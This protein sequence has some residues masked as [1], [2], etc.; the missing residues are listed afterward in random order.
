MSQD[1]ETL[2][3]FN[4]LENETQFGTP[5]T[6]FQIPSYRRTKDRPPI[7][8]YRYCFIFWI[9]LGAMASSSLMNVQFQASSS[10]S[11]VKDVAQLERIGAHSHITGLGLNELLEVVES[12]SHKDVAAAAADSAA[13]TAAQ[14][15]SGLVGQVKARRALGIIAKLIQSQQISGRSVLLAGP[16]STGK[17]ALAM[18]LAT[19]LLGCSTTATSG[20]TSRNASGTINDSSNSNNMPFVNLAASSVYSVDLSKTEALTQAVR[21]SIGVQIQEEA[22]LIVGEVVEIQVDTSTTAASATTGGGLKKTGRI[23]L[24]TT[25]METV[26]DLG[27]K[28][29][30]MLMA[31]KVQAGDVIKID[32]ASGKISKLGRSVSKSREYDAISAQQKYVSTPEG[33]LMQR[34]TIT[35]TVS[36]H[37]MDVINSRQQ[38]FLALFAGDTGEIPDTIRDQI[39]AKVTEWRE[40]GRAVLQPGVLFIDEVHMLDME[41]FSFLN[42][43]LEQELAPALL[44]IATNRGHSV[45]RGTQYESPHG[46]PLDL[47]DR[48]MIVPTLPYTVLELRQIL[49]VRCREE[50]VTI[51]LEAMELLTRIAHECTLRYAMHLITVSQL[52]A[53]KRHRNGATKTSTASSSSMVELVDVERCYRLFVDV[54]RSTQRLLADHGDVGYMF[55]ELSSTNEAEPSVASS[56]KKDLTCIAECDAP[57]EESAEQMQE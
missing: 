12:V 4:N 40:E 11:V 15:R 7:P 28:M 44:I 13:V 2:I 37:E 23:T 26:Y 6:A 10:S 29:I 32:K 36:L 38:G 52:C 16:P 35:H 22:E 34:Q 57:I 54:Q 27:Q 33:E 17:T 3:T 14:N 8:S 5:L 46:I 18:A 39:D 20:T 24:C 50:G 49:Q 30:A 55:N 31:E 48:L 53:T 21:R 43:A 42:R 45:I 1:N 41:C 9:E 19:E 47:L 25:D 51:H 56:L